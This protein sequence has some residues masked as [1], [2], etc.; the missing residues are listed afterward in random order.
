MKKWSL[1]TL[2]LTVFLV[3]AACGS[4]EATKEEENSNTGSD[5]PVEET[6]EIKIKHELDEQEVVLDKTPEK[7]V[8]FDFG[9]LDTLNE[10]GVP[11]TGLPQATIPPYLEKYAGSDYTNVGS[12]KEPDFEAIHAL[13]PDVIFISARQSDMYEEFKKIAPTIYV[14]V[15][16]TNYMESFTHNMEVIA[17]VFGKEEQM[18]TELEEVNKAIAA[19]KEKTES[20]DARTLIIMGNEGK[21]SAYGPSSRFGIL[22]DV[23]GYEPADEKIEQS[24][25]GQSISFEYISETNPDIMFVIDR[26]AA[27]DSNAS[28]KDAIENELVQKTNAFNNGKIFY[29]NGGP[30]YLSGGGLQ[31]MKL[32]IEDAKVGVE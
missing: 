18:K 3:L 7:V 1:F 2:I 17:Q 25:H 8:V 6:V 11:V 28:V 31:S 24:T 20:S 19:I 5:K 30:W 9:I 10:L 14:G 23:F 26:D 15:D 21:V 29:L 13:K 16:Y 4:K 27:F 22:H 12:L 32:M